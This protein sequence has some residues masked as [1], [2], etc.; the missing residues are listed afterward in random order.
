MCLP[1]LPLT[2]SVTFIKVLTLI[3]CPLLRTRLITGLTS[4]HAVRTKRVT[5][6]KTVPATWWA[7]SRHQLSSFMASLCSYI[8]HLSPGADGH[9]PG[10]ST[11]SP[12]E[13]LLCLWGDVA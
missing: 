12:R 13:A 4:H 10:P 1:T 5:K 8:T 3:S 2:S 7:L 11:L 6:H 9:F